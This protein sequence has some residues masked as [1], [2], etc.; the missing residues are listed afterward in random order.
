MYVIVV[1]PIRLLSPAYI[2]AARK[3]AHRRAVRLVQL[4][5][6]HQ[7]FGASREGSHR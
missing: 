1:D 2:G 6:L 4:A 7:R 5:F 3:V